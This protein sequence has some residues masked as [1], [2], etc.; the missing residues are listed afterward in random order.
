MNFSRISAKVD[1]SDPKVGQGS[2][3]LPG[4][5]I[6]DPNHNSLLEYLEQP[7]LVR[8][9]DFHTDALSLFDDLELEKPKGIGDELLDLIEEKSAPTPMLAAVAPA[10]MMMSLNQQPQPQILNQT[11]RRRTEATTLMKSLSVPDPLLG[12]LVSESLTGFIFV[13]DGQE[14][15]EY[16]SDSSSEQVGY[17]PEQIRG[18]FIK[19]FLHPADHSKFGCHILHHQNPPTSNT[20][21]DKARRNFTCRFKLLQNNSGTLL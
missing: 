5:S 12:Q 13:V 1:S 11:E 14:R 17:A 4:S 20:D 3:G 2:A 21:P 8:S 6:A 15:V 10:N 19:K 7:L 18:N 16:V 9:D